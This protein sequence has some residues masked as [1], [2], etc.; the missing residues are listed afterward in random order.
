MKGVI[1]NL[2]E[3]FI[4]DGWGEQAYEEIFAQCP[5]QTKE[6]FVGLNSYPDADLLTIVAKAAAQFDISVSDAVRAFGKYC[7]PKL[8][9]KYPIFVAGHRHPK[10]FL[11]SIDNVIHVEVRKLLKDAEPPRM[12]FVDPAPDQ[13]ILRYVSKRQLCPLVSGLLDGT[14][15][16]FR[17]PIGHTQTQC[18]Q[19]GASACEFHLTFENEVGAFA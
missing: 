15:E 13:L 17:T 11:M 2:L 4:T 12:F 14:A 1:F 9:A 5:L 6:A 16:Y 10:T 8:V 18:T 7:L 3:D 19:S